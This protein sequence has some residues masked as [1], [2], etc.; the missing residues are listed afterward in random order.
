MQAC[1]YHR[2]SL[3]KERSHHEIKLKHPHIHNPHF[4]YPDDLP[5]LKKFKPRFSP[6]ILEKEKKKKKKK[7]KAG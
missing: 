7:K 1:S 5:G 2:V 6:I 3:T 4:V